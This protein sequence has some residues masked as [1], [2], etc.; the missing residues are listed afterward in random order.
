MTPSREIVHI[1]AD[2]QPGG[3]STMLLGLVDQQ[4]EGRDWVPTVV[5]Q[6][7]SYLE[8]QALLRG[9]RFIGL[10]F[11]TSLFDLHL[12]S[13]LHA[14]LAGR[15]YALSHLHG[16]RAAHHS[17]QAPLRDSLGRLV[18]TVHG[19]HQL[20]LPPPLR[21]AANVAERRVMR[22]VD[23]RVFVSQA[24]QAAAVAARLVPR[25]GESR[26][27]HNGVDVQRVASVA[28]LERIYDVA[29][30]GRH[31]RPKGPL[32][33]ARILAR[34]AAAGR[35]CTMAGAGPLHAECAA[36]LRTLP[37][38]DRVSCEG[39]LGRAEA[40]ALIARTRV[41]IMPSLWEGLPLLPMEA[42]ALGVPV[43]ATRLPGIAEVID[44]GV[45]GLLT[46]P[47]DEGAMLDAI[48]SLLADESLQRGLRAAGRA[49]VEQH[50]DHRAVAAAYRQTYL[51][52]LAT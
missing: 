39:E 2:G 50:F 11:F 24:D 25:A 10:D 30:V 9:V 14:A 40:L 18:Y 37:G 34:L 31:D 44:D 20:H 47:G 12:A 51:G 15:R 16:L 43:V 49:R 36:L 35:R 29:F 26:V 8:S 41:L 32:A 6:P 46:P 1:V 33:A 22:R 27:I 13:K 38:G 23:A 21:W 42:M 5:S 19:L 4:I 17:V 7:G 45:T 28:S 52:V 48:E 3:G